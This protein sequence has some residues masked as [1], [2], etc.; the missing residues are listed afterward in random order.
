MDGAYTTYTYSSA[1]TCPL[2]ADVYV[3]AAQGPHP[4]IV[5]LHGGALIM[6]H[7]SQL[8]ADEA[9]AWTRA[10][11]AVVAV[12]YRL[13]PETKLPGI[14]DDLRAAF[15][16]VRGQGP[17]LF[18]ADPA[19]VAALGASA[20]GYLALMAGFCTD[21]RPR[22][23]VAISG[24]GDVTA[25]WYSRPDPF[26]CRQPL[27]T[28]QQ[29]RAAVGSAETVG[30]LDWGRGA[31]YLWCRQQGRW[32]TEVG[33][34]D[35]DSERDWFARYCPVRHVTADFPPTIL[36]HGDADTDVPCE[37]SAL[38]AEALAR[39]GVTHEFI[40]IPGGE[41]CSLGR[42]R[43]EKARTRAR[44][45]A[46]LERFVGAPSDGPDPVSAAAGPER[47]DSERC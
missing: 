36:V 38:M 11:Y 1:H 9:A 7:R 29:A 32:P 16:W 10:G 15:S 21:P 2:Q 31:F 24:Y 45:L 44:I 18:G 20:G 37:Q 47:E 23:L 34:H 42:D 40:A 30:E 27:V 26:Y 4:V 35:P 28:E 41:H 8:S 6:G 39:A 17:A 43:A 5:W 19:R 14:M 3:P 33:G 12:D 13:A 46:F 22:A 25:D